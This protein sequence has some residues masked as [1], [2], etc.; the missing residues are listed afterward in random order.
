MRMVAPMTINQL[1]GLSRDTPDS[2]TCFKKQRHQ[3]TPD[4]PSASSDRDFRANLL[5]RHARLAERK[6]GTNSLTMKL[7]RGKISSA[8]HEPTRTRTAPLI[9]PATEKKWE[10][11]R[12]ATRA[13]VSAD[14][15]PESCTITSD[16]SASHDHGRPLSVPD[17]RPTVISLGVGP[18]PWCGS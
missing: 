6:A 7:G 15:S 14:P 17:K 2:K 9:L 11:K 10:G 5:L 8:D 1:T 3:P 13:A 16:P 4:V 18:G 12:R